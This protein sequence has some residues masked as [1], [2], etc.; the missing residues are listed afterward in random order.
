MIAKNAFPIHVVNILTFLTQIFMRLNEDVLSA[1]PYL[2]PVVANSVVSVEEVVRWREE[3]N[4]S[5][6][7][8]A[9]GA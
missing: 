9:L 1:W 6:T 8:F 4:Q 7:F 3:T 2:R 5:L